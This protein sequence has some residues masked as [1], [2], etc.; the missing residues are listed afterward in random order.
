M[1]QYTAFFNNKTNTIFEPVVETRYNC[2]ISDDRMD[3]Y[4][5]KTNKLYLYSY[6]GGSLENLDNIPSCMIGDD[7]YEAEQESKGVYSISV[8]L[9]S[10]DY[11]KDMII[12]DTWGNLYYQGEKI[13]DAELEFVTKSATNFFSVSNVVSKPRVLNPMITGINANEK[14]NR[15]EE[16]VIRLY[17]KEP[18]THTDFEL[19]DN[20]QYRIYVKDGERELTVVDWDEINKMNKCNLFTIKTDEYVPADYHVDIRA[21][22]GGN[23]RIYKDELN[24][25]IV[26]DMEKQTL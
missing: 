25:T 18:Y 20:C 23:V 17:F 4:L 8:T 16:R 2:K 24:Y 3:F 26:S 19:V 5:N 1:T 15:G 14:L 12:Y 6:I 10:K 7:M 9:S 13:N 22:F 21:T 11:T